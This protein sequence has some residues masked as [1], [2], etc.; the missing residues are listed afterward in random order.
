M[1]NYFIYINI[2]GFAKYYFDLA[3]K[4]NIPLYNLECLINEGCYFENLWTG[5]PSITFP[6]QS[7]ILSGAYSNV[8]GNVSKYFDKEKN[9]IV[10]C[11]HLNYGE[12]FGEVLRNKNNSLISIQQFVLN[13]RGASYED[14]DFLYLQ[15]GGDY[16]KRFNILL[17]LLRNNR[18]D[19][20][21]KSIFY[22]KIPKFIFLYVD[23]LDEVGHNAIFNYEGLMAFSERKRISKVISRLQKIDI[24][25]GEVI[26]AL[27]DKKIY[28]RSYILITSDHGMVPFK[29]RSSIPRLIKDLKKC[30][31]KNIIY[32]DDLV[33]KEYENNWDVV[34]TSTGI[35]VQVWFNSTEVDLNKIKHKLE[36]K[37][38]IEKALTR[39]ELIDKGVFEGFSDILVSPIPPYHFNGNISKRFLLRGGHDSLNEGTQRIFGVLK[40]PLIKENFICKDSVKNIDLIPT[41]CEILKIPVMRSSTGTIIRKVIKSK[42]ID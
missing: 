30:G 32:T 33:S 14:R 29:G 15:P 36:K 3:R 25:I 26:K 24:K 18:V 20:G 23:D 8:T 37:D 35:E 1:E 31:F 12:T 19:L 21:E 39:D 16:K 17:E 28:K 38:Y 5:I 9:K 41:L 11:K 4:L 2:D 13:S 27:I 40:G 10:Y 42:E 22:D 7:S 34:M 6:M